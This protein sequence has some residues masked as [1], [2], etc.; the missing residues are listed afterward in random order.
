MKLQATYTDGVGLRRCDWCLHPALSTAD[1]EMMRSALA[2]IINM[3]AGAEHPA[4][5]R[6][7]RAVLACLQEPE[8]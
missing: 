5:E 1:A 8:P 3:A 4:I 7:A 2:V 6:L